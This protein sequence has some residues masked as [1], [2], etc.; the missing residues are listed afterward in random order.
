[1]AAARLERINQLTGSN[2]SS[3]LKLL[4]AYESKNENE[5]LI[6]K[7]KPNLLLLARRMAVLTQYNHLKQNNQTV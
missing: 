1:M 3:I 2:Q 7:D 5:P 6:I 4:Q